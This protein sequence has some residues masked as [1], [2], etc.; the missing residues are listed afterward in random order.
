MRRAI[1]RDDRGAV[2]VHVAVALVGLLAFSSLT[3]DYGVLWVARRQAQNAADAAAL[4]AAHSLAYGDLTDMTTL[5]ARVKA[6]GVSVAQQHLVWGQA[7]SVTPDDITIITCPPLTPGV[8]DQCVRVEVFRRQGRSPLPTF[9]GNLVGVTSQGVQATATAQVAV[10]ATTSCVRPWAIPDKWLDRID[11][12]APKDIDTWTMDDTFNRYYESGAL[13]GE[14]L[15]PVETLDEYVPSM[16]YKVPDD[17]G[18]RVKLKVGSPQDTIS[19]G[20]FLP[21]SIGGTGGNVYQENIE[22]CNPHQF[23]IGDV[24]STEEGV[25]VEPG[26][27]IGPTKHGV[28]NLIA[29]DTLMNGEEAVWKCT[30]GHVASANEDC[31]GYP[32][33]GTSLR[34]V[35]LPVFDVQAYLDEKYFGEDKTTGRFNLKITRLVGF[36]IERMQGNDVIGRVTY[37]PANGTLGSGTANNANFLRKIILVR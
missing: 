6:V 30:D 8:P 33:T 32:S 19:P 22:E 11:D 25:E 1:W 17:I 14:L 18:L 3:I 9:F 15:G 27:M 24:L 34:I 23:A 35:P 5:T 31:A 12:D 21:I 29:A 16:G 13:K 20:F 7:P 4:A 37:Y 28:D 26:N 36:F 2:L 10:G